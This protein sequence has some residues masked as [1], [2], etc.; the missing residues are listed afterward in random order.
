MSW[1][2]EDI[3]SLFHKSI[4][5][6]SPVLQTQH[7]ISPKC[8][9]DTA[10]LA[11]ETWETFKKAPDLEVVPPILRDRFGNEPYGSATSTMRKIPW[12]WHIPWEVQRK[13]SFSKKGIGTPK[14]P[15]KRIY[16]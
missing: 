14:V 5:D 10:H 6:L 13:A 12:G 16:G 8:Q 11:V 1:G 15:R 2:E 9:P 7:I 3:G 4:I